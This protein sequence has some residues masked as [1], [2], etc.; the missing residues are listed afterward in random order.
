MRIIPIALFSALSLA[1][2]PGAALAA[3]PAPAL[4]VVKLKPGTEGQPALTAVDQEVMQ[5]LERISD[6]ETGEIEDKQDFE[7]MV[8]IADSAVPRLTVVLRDQNARF[9]H[10]WVSA[11]ALGKIGG[12]D[13]TK[14]LRGALADDK[15][16]MIR[17]AAITGLIDL[18]DTGSYDAF[19]KALGD[20]AMVV[21]SAAADALGALGDA[22][23]VDPLVKALD[24]EDNF[25]RGRSLWVRRHIVAAL[26][27]IESRSS[28]HRLIKALDD[29]DP[30]V[31][32]EAIASLEKVTK[33]SFRV[34]AT[35]DADRVT[36][37]TPKW[38]SWWEENK[39]DY[40]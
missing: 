4:E 36:R 3:E 24:R 28:V 21:R 9:D 33:V 30:T 40:L 6:K 8:S 32:R 29:A 38:K 37:T 16:S 10:R 35:N 13:A 39:K 22:K 23:A 12:N 14:T 17:L 15:F 27:R 25:Y 34:P 11:R 2:A 19:V 31:N 20:D 5:I 1:A 18:G 7:R 26:G